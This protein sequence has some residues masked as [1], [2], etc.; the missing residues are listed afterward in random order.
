MYDKMLMQDILDFKTGADNIYEMK[1]RYANIQKSI[2][3]RTYDKKWFAEYL[4]VNN[5]I[6]LKI[7]NELI[8][9]VKSDYTKSLQFV[10]GFITK[11]EL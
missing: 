10:M 4:M 7:Y 5:L 1:Y 3:R 8:R 11:E 6:N 9:R 2:K